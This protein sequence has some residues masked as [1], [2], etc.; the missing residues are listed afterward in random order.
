MKQTELSLDLYNAAMIRLKT[1]DS[2]SADTYSVALRAKD[3][4][5]D[6]D[7][8][9]S[10]QYGTSH[11]QA[12]LI[13]DF[14]RLPII[15]TST[16]HET[17]IDSHLAER[18]YRSKI[19]EKK[20]EFTPAPRPAVLQT[21][22]QESSASVEVI[23]PEKVFN[24]SKLIR[25][26]MPSMI[27]IFFVPQFVS[28]FRQT[29]TPD[30]VK[31]VFLVIAIFFLGIVPLIGLIIAIVRSRK[32]RTV[33]TASTEGIKI[34]YRGILRTK[35]R[36]IPIADILGLDYSTAETVWKSVRQSSSRQPKKDFSVDYESMGY[37]GRTPRWMRIFKKFV[38][39][40]GIIIKSRSGLI[41]FGAGLPDEEVQYLF[42][43]VKR[44]IVERRA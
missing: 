7:L 13:A 30:I 32:C 36:H 24:P 3:G 22:V 5:K 6:L 20:E 43:L 10:T 9:R 37:I 27:L 35:T 38:K 39:S 42:S 41:T 25:Y 14:L 21:Q 12:V 2:D 1:G 26:M 17:V 4:S 31:Y 8:Y 40:K 44:V 16:D 18:S 33:V 15:D 29:N 28:F 34:D 19:D 11:E 23:I